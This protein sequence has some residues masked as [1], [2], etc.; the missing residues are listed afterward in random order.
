MI[1]FVQSD[2][3]ELEPNSRFA[4]HHSRFTSFI[5]DFKEPKNL[6]ETISWGWFG[7]VKF[8]ESRFWSGSS[9][10]WEFPF[11]G[12]D[13]KLIPKRGQEPPNVA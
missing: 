2:G 3:G 1:D 9:D 4:N 11:R 7:S 12:R 10:A 5:Y 8:S 13:I 6:E